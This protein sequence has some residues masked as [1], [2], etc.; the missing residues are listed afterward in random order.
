MN[1]TKLN[2]EIVES[3]KH[4]KDIVKKYQEPDNKK[5]VVQLM[6]SFLPYLGLWV[7]MY[8]SLNWSI[9][10]T[11]G[12][13]IINAFFLVRIFIIQHDCGHQSFMKSKKLNNFVGYVCSVFSGLPYKYWARVHNYHHAHSGVLETIEIGDI[14]TLTVNEFRKLTRWGRI[15]YKT[16]RNPFVTFVIAPA[17]YIGLSNKMPIFLFKNLKKEIW[18]QFKNNVLIV[19]VYVLLAYLLGWKQFLFVQLFLVFVFGIIAF[20]FFYIQHQHE[21]SYKQWQSNWNYVVSAIRGSTYYKLPKMFQWMTGN[22]GIHHI[23][24]L[25]SLIP[26][27]NLDKCMRENSILNKYVTVV[28]FWES[29]KMMSHK[30]WD[31]EKQRMISFKEYYQMEKM[32]LA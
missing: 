27:Y 16:W 32:R 24:H 7:L 28:T 1:H 31:E 9:F 20:W 6:T 10:I 3:L 13:G 29:L 18:N 22:I 8:F 11:I 23:H 12:L 19:G 30:L 25:S 21:H 15:R 26:N 2:Q 14:P 5:A 4:W 17:Y